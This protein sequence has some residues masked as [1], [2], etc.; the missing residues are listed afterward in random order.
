MGSPPGRWFLGGVLQLRRGF[1]TLEYSL[2]H[3][4]LKVLLMLGRQVASASAG[5]HS[6]TKDTSMIRVFRMAMRI[7]CLCIAVVAIST[8]APRV[9]SADIFQWKWVDEANHDLG[10]SRSSQLCP[11][12]D[13]IETWPSANSRDL[14][15]AY[16]I[17]ANLSSARIE[18]CNLTDA[19]LSNANLTN[20]LV[21]NTV[22]DGAD[23]TGAT[24]TGA[25]FLG[26]QISTGQLYTTTSYLAHDLHNVYFEGNPTAQYNLR[27]CDFVNQNLRNAGFYYSDLSGAAFSGSQ[28]VGT[29]FVASQITSTQL[30][31]TAS[32]QSRDL[33]NVSFYSV[34]VAGWNLAN[35]NLSGARFQNCSLANVGFS[36]ANI[37]GAMFVWATPSAEQLY[38]TANYAARNL[39]GVWF[40]NCNLTGRNF[41]NQNLQN[42][43]FIYSTLAD[44]DFS[45]ATVK[46]A[47]FMTNGWGYRSITQQQLSSTASYKN[48]DLQ[49]IGFANNDLIGWNFTQQNL[50]GATFDSTRLKGASF[51]GANLTNASFRT[52]VLSGANLTGATLTGASFMYADLRGA[53]GVSVPSSQL[54]GAIAPD[55]SLNPAYFTVARN[56]DQNIPIHVLGD[57]TMN[58]GTRTL[59]FLDQQPWHSSIRFDPG[60][61]VTLHG[62]LSLQL[63]FGVNGSDLIG[64][65][66]KLF[67]WSDAQVTGRFDTIYDAVSN[68]PTPHV[69]DVSSLYTTGEMRFLAVAEPCTCGLLGIGAAGMLLAG[70]LRRRAMRHVLSKSN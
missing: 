15:K 14:T 68:S 7:C 53:T 29:V 12:G 35:Q 64:K 51:A 1:T 60:A 69:L 65:S 22:L 32:Y 48:K 8:A 5:K 63:D 62:Q 4:A 10:K 47:D 59:F 50:T 3:V 37:S 34:D 38:S 27:N 46:G 57:W 20:L 44:A 9:Y 16:L 19:E 56:C 55:G 6:T 13:D 36:G 18:Q 21:I 31:S 67:D 66:F 42:A 23:F 28:I 52:A 58:S 54:Q 40:H 43:Q 25:M 49:G 45:G 11:G 17:G 41:A 2:L 26:S 24:V 61:T 70:Y 39:Q 30:Y 33:Q